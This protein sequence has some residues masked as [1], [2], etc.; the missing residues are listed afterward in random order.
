VW[1]SSYTK[2]DFDG[3]YS[4]TETVSGSDSESVTQGGVS[5][6]NGNSWSWTRSGTVWDDGR[7]NWNESWS[8]SS[9]QD[10]EYTTSES[11]STGGGFDPHETGEQVNDLP[12]VGEA[13]RLNKAPKQD[14]PIDLQ[15]PPKPSDDIWQLPTVIIKEPEFKDVFENPINSPKPGGGSNPPP[16]PPPDFDDEDLNKCYDLLKKIEEVLYQG[17][18][19]E[20][21]NFEKSLRKREQDM[22][23]D[24]NT[25][26]LYQAHMAAMAGYPEAENRNIADGK[27][28]WA[29]HQE[30]YRKVREK[31]RRLLNELDDSDC[32]DFD[33]EALGAENLVNTA[34]EYAQKEPPEQ[35]LP[36]TQRNTLL[37]Q[38]F[39]LGAK[40]KDGIL[41]VAEGLSNIAIAIL[42][43]I[44]A[45]L[46]LPF[47]I[48]PI[49][50]KT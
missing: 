43:G 24:N 32:D 3:G 41:V 12:D 10:G 4:W 28:S 22:L 6:S 49:L 34:R 11:E 44:A 35:P 46:S 40:L 31:L 16:L 39:A 21:G 1:N 29:G 25:N 7:N 37:Q 50:P 38:A 36:P 23:N 27:G 48:L 2:S 15:K 13:P 14:V 45:V 5:T 17:F 26:R 19:N 18:T 47:R 33:L 9:W 42:V 30:R 20:Q 8:K